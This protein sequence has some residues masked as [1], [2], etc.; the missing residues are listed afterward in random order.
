M[1][2]K[3]LHEELYSRK[4][5]KPNSFLYGAIRGLGILIYKRKYGLNFEYIDDPRNEEGPIVV[6]ANHASR[7]D[8]L[9]SGIPCYPVKFNFLAAY[10]EFFRGNLA[11][12][13]KV[14]QLIPKR[15]FYSDSYAA[16]ETVRLVK[17]QK[18][19][20]CFYPE[21][22]SSI[23][24]ANQPCA[25]GTGKL[26]KLLN[27]PVYSCVTSGAYLIQPKY[28]FWK[29]ERYAKTE[30]KIQKVFV[31]EEL[32]KL[33][34][35]EIEKKVDEILY[36]DDYE[37]AKKNHIVYKD[38]KEGIAED[39][40]A[41]LYKCPKCSHE[42]EMETKGNR[43]YCKH[44]GNE[45]YIENDYTIHPKDDNC[46]I[47]AT[48]TKRFN[49]IRIKEREEIDKNPDFTF[50]VE[51]TLGV[52]PKNRHM[53]PGETAV[54]VGTGKLIL[55]RKN[56]FSYIG[57]MNNEPYEIHISNHDLYTFI[58]CYNADIIHFFYKGELRQFTFNR[59]G[60]ATKV[61]I[62][63]NELHRQCGGEWQMP[64]Y[65]KY[66]ENECFKD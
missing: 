42:F 49:Y 1:S 14:M 6:I 63:Q 20:L 38:N 30:T 15:Q 60:M 45:A 66:D 26:L 25:P 2:K 48:Q 64:S 39:L 46:R 21:G 50:E 43:I 35:E 58:M 9:F 54:T 29:K 41:L 36:N 55:S 12:L 65:F 5:H 4:L 32:K 23:H 22:L 33:S 19:S 37:W 28:K 27:V 40:E 52:I 34:P 3:N 47:P 62:L 11:L 17:N 18:R 13:F 16:F 44:C 59:K 8:Y 7:N 10:N 53:R 57:T 61:L 56:G 31:P 51:T 24:G